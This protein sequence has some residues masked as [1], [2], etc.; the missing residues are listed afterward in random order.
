MAMIASCLACQ[1]D[2]T[3]AEYCLI[4]PNI[5]GCNGE[6]VVLLE[7]EVCYEH[8][9]RGTQINYPDKCANGLICAPF[10]TELMNGGGCGLQAYT[11]QYQHLFTPEKVEHHES[12]VADHMLTHFILGDDWINDEVETMWA[13]MSVCEKINYKVLKNAR[14]CTLEIKYLYKTKGCCPY[15]SSDGSSAVWYVLLGAGVCCCFMTC[16]AV[17]GCAEMQ[18][19]K[20]NRMERRMERI[21]SEKT[22]KDQGI[23]EKYYENRARLALVEEQHR[24]RYMNLHRSMYG[25]AAA[26]AAATDDMRY[27]LLFNEIL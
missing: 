13:D 21:M 1:H 5:E 19:R 6:D 20:A 18:R 14:Q 17:G 22:Y 24:Q 3:V 2:L 8:C 25:G 16:A 26:S 23:L 15:T 27:P 11:C 4:H 12:S 9:P 10:S 7:N